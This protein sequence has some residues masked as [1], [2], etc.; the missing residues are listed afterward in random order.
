MT[1]GPTETHGRGG[2]P[3]TLVALLRHHAAHR[4]G[5]LAYRFLGGGTD[6]PGAPAPGTDD[7]TSSADANGGPGGER[8]WTYAE[9]DLRARHVAALLQ[10]E[11]AAGEPVLLLH[12]PGLDY[13]AA[14]MGCLY[15][16]AV[17]VPAYPPDTRRFGQTMP[18]LAAIAR[19]S[20][21]THALTTGGLSRFAGDRRD[22]LAALGLGGL[23]WL[24]TGG[25]DT[26][27][28]AG[29]REPDLT[30]DSL[31][32]LQYTSGS[33]SAPKGVMVGHGNLLHNLAGIHRRLAHDAD[34]AMVSWLPPYH[35]MGLIGGILSP[36][37]GGFPAHLMAP[38]TFV[39]RPLLWLATLSDTRASTSVAPNFGF[40]AC[41]RRITDEERGRLDLSH[42]RLALNGA[43][44][45]RADTLDR[46]VERFEPCGFRRG[47]LLPC[48][49]LAE[50][51]L[52]VT[53][54][55]AHEQPAVGEFDAA[56]L[57]AGVATAAS[58]GRV[59]RVVG[60][61]PPV[62]GVDVAV[63]DPATQR[64]VAGEGTVGEVWIAGGSVARGYWRRPDATEDTFRARIEGEPG[65][66]YLR[67]GDLGF[68][69][70][71]QLHV[72]GRTKDVVI[73]QGRNH[74]PHD[75][76]L[77]VE[78]TDSAVRSGCGAAFAVEV[79]G[80]EQLVVAYEIDGRRADDAPA[81]LARLRSAIADEH[82]VAPHAVVL[83]KRSTVPK[84]TSG[85]IQR[86]AC[87]QDF[88]G[89]GLKVVAASVAREPR[90]PGGT[91]GR[92]PGQPVGAVVEE[93]LGAY[94][95]DS[96]DASGAAGAVGAA[97]RTFA[98]LGLD[99]PRLLAVAGDLERRL[100]V[101]V[102][103]GEL[104]VRPS[105]EAL[106]E[107]LAER[108]P[109]GGTWAPD[110]VESWLTARVGERLGLAPEAIDPERPLASLGLDSKQ[111]V[112][113]LAELSART[114]R[115]IPATAVFDHPTIRAIAAHLAATGAEVSE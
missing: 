34:S 3:R 20:R 65:G 17:A 45:V 72:V 86:Q 71:G 88:L 114:G 83:L 58:G 107:L 16:G 55:R 39:R 76:E 90:R 105:V 35:D 115:E 5:A 102:P 38:M 46:F 108:A 54:V 64:R 73:V 68:L 7:G 95:T 67:T 42:W 94:V 1:Q 56:A 112:A 81:L 103:V 12:P 26:P 48:Y 78:R 51:T 92:R 36:L 93:V 4:P 100:G 21:A 37:Y 53:G 57:G 80:A 28:A 70:D 9:L 99:Y 44:P 63:V 111:A 27:T 18:R 89:L 2:E 40:E 113:V 91:V 50:A 10:H 97:G 62:D 19:D 11:G 47:A 101:S 59:T 96:G 52:M 29:W 24:V 61:G 30:G 32:F 33:T 84:T 82:E 110:T 15:A 77:T 69:R 22:E 49:G 43:E 109:A 60:C 85:K 31:A 75:V 41:V 13:I 6:A 8:S 14:F 98:D 74:Y 23:R 104:L 79:D 25:A 66:P 106:T 87:R